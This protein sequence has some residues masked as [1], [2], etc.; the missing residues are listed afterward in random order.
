[1]DVAL[2]SYLFSLVLLRV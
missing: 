2:E 1:M